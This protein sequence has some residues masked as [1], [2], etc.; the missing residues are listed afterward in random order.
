MMV[1]LISVAAEAALT[2]G[3]LAEIDLASGGAGGAT[4]KGWTLSADGGTARPIKVP[5]GGWNSDWQ[6]P[7]IDTMTGVVD[8]VVY[9]R[10]ILVPEIVADQVTKISFGAVNYGAD[11]FANDK[12]MGSHVGSMTPFEVDISSGVVPGKECTLKVKAYHRRHYMVPVGGRPKELS[13]FQT[14][15]GV[16]KVPTM[17]TCSI[18]VSIDTPVGSQNWVGCGWFGK[19][20]FAYG[21]IRHIKMKVLPPIYVEEVFVKPSVSND[22]LTVV[23][24]IR[25]SLTV[26]K[27]LVLS[28][29]FSPWNSGSWQYP[30]LPDI[31]M[32]IPAGKSKEVVIGPLKWGLGP[33]SYWWPNI[34]FREDYAATL[35]S[36]LLD[37]K[38]PGLLVSKKHHTYTQRF[39]F[40]E[41]SEGPYYYMVNG[42]RVFQV[43]DVTTESQIG[44][45]DSYATV[46]AFLPPTGPKTGC[47]ET[48][49][50]YMR[51]GINANR[52]SCNIPTEYMLEAADEVGFMLIP[53]A[54]TFGNNIDVYGPVHDQTVKEMGL[55]CRNHPSVIRYSL[56][57][58]IRGSM[59][60]WRPLIDAMLEVDDTRPLLFECQGTP[61]TKFPG[62]KGGH[63]YSGAHYGTIMKNPGKAIYNMGEYCWGSDYMMEA[64]ILGMQMRLYDWA[65]VAP[66]CW[67]NYWPNFFEGINSEK[68]VQNNFNGIDRVDNVNGWG[69]PVVKLV[70]RALHPYLLL[71]LGIMEDTNNVPVV[72]NGNNG[73]TPWHEKGGGDVYWPRHLPTCTGGE[74]VERRIEIFNGGLAGSELS[75]KWSAHWDSPSGPVAVAGETI[76][77]LETQ[78]GFHVTRTIRFPVPATDN[79]GR[80]LYLVMESIKDGTVVYT[81][82]RIYFT[83][84][85]QKL[86]IRD[87]S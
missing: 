40:C 16:K 47:P 14:N 77:P 8:Y 28:V 62:I 35:H 50:R 54:V 30:A 45:Y 49:R 5:G 12:L 22:T 48:W 58:E 32:V 71:D 13:P 64:G 78:P 73:K 65:Y 15:T 63:A 82:D 29:R 74:T 68:H 76:G 41:H 72:P 66:W 84:G 43:G 70:Q 33:K 38:E 42:V 21:I 20:K 31:P 2:H 36:L 19:D 39:G 23:V 11:V 46:P 44:N 67:L 56:G 87:E 52:V 79:V 75:L 57:N 24:S 51:C 61:G 86:E 27:S 10:K 55:L 3:A 6:E 60:P 17:L 7:R 85:I 80:R 37:I 4:G 1:M 18:P 83:V 34:P 59:E 53:E 26:E 81:E 25:N 69:S 9:E